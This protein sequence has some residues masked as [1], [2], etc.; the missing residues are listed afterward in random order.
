[1]TMEDVGDYLKSKLNSTQIQNIK[2][3]WQNKKAS[4]VTPAV[5]A[6]IKNMD[7]PTQLAIKQ[8]NIPHISKLVEQSCECKCGQSPCK[9]CGKDHHNVKEDASKMAQ[10]M[11]TGTQKKIADLSARIKDTEARRKDID[12][13]DKTQMAINKADVHHMQLKLA[14]LKDKLRLDRAKRSLAAQNEPKLPNRLMAVEQIHPAK[15]LIEDI[16]KKRSKK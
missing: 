10:A 15:S 1:M 16:L 6:H 8:A 14:D 5:K 2:K 12:V 9:S 7:I 11:A 13:G 4:D 3:T